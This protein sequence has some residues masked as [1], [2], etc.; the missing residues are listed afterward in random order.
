MRIPK[1]ELERRARIVAMAREQHEREGEV[2]IDEGAKLSE[3]DDNG[4]YVAAWVWVDYSGTEF[5]RSKEDADE[6]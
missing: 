4:C 6:N 1:K 3:G 2:E 5:D